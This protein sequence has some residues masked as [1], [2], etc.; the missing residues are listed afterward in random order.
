MSRWSEATWTLFIMTLII[1]TCFGTCY[2][3]SSE[4]SL[5]AY[6]ACLAVSPAQPERCKVS[7]TVNQGQQ[8]WP[9]F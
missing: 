8:A 3:R 9:A 7:T 4:H 6:K 5:E 1:G 2:T